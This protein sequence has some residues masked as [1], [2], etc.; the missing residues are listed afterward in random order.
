M[1]LCFINLIMAKPRSLSKL[2]S[3]A[4]HQPHFSLI[5]HHKKYFPTQ[6]K[7]GYYS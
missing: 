7:F 2:Y 4:Q 1:T 5:I 6:Y 3:R